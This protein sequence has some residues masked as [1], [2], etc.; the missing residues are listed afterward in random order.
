M[1]QCYKKN[2]NEFNIYSSQN[3]AT[4][5]LSSDT[6]AKLDHKIDKSTLNVAVQGKSKVD[7]RQAV[8][9]VS[10]SLLKLFSDQTLFSLHSIQHTENEPTASKADKKL[11]KQSKQQHRYTRLNQNCT[12]K[13]AKIRKYIKIYSNET[14]PD[15]TLRHSRVDKKKIYTNTCILLI[16]VTQL[17]QVIQ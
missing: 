10:I 12:S 6:Q 1:K 5:P 8:E 11:K 13:P 15:T 2:K 14:L 9:L 3:C 7:N 16:P 17:V 4:Q